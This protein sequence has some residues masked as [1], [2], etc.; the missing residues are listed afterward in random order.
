MP[1]PGPASSVVAVVTLLVTGTGLWSGG[2][3]P[4]ATWPTQWEPRNS[5]LSLTALA[6]GPEAKSPSLLL[7]EV[8]LLPPT[9]ATPGALVTEGLPQ[10]PQ[11]SVMPYP[12]Q[13]EP[14][15]CSLEEVALSELPS[16]CSGQVVEAARSEQEVLVSGESTAES[17]STV[18]VAE[19]ADLSHRSPSPL[20][21]AA[22]PL[23]GAAGV[24]A[25]IDVA[26]LV[27]FAIGACGRRRTSADPSPL[28]E[29][30][31]QQQKRQQ[32]QQQQ[33]QMQL[34]EV[35]NWHA[36]QSLNSKMQSD[37]QSEVQLQLDLNSATDARTAQTATT[38]AA[39]I[40]AETT[41]DAPT[42]QSTRPVDFSHA[43]Q[44]DE[45]LSGLIS[46]TYVLLT[47]TQNGNYSV[48]S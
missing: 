7:V 34:Q 18:T 23:A 31:Q 29:P 25:V 1:T 19:S 20:S 46:E 4:T 38:T 45:Q 24:A 47:S 30:R 42:A 32:Q 2:R 13:P 11:A 9:P 44:E 27:W 5:Q 12:A 33:V 22:W 39:E 10:M 3:M 43:E 8:P 36:V 35:L 26:L 40:T 41:S 6:H 28:A 14:T 17:P 37:T 48:V 16:A 15:S 21:D